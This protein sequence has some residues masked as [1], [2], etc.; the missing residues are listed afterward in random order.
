RDSRSICLVILIGTHATQ[1]WCADSIPPS[2]VRLRQYMAQVEKIAAE[3]GPFPITSDYSDPFATAV[4]KSEDLAEDGK[5]A[6]AAEVLSALINGQIAA[7]WKQMLQTRIHILKKWHASGRIELSEYRIF[8]LE[9]GPEW[10]HNRARPIAA[11]WQKEIGSEVERYFLIGALLAA[12]HDSEGQ[13]IVLSAIPDV[14]GVSKKAAADALLGVGHL[15]HGSGDLSGAETNW[16]KVMLRYA[17]LPAWP[18]AVFNLGILCKEKKRYTEA[19]A[20]FN[21]LL[22]SKPNDTEAYREYSHSSA[23]ELSQ[24]YEALS[25]YTIALKWAREAQTRYPCQ[26]SRGTGLQEEKQRN[27]QR[28]RELE[29]KLSE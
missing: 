18:E 25:N 15:L 6:E 21:T 23:V 20:F 14:D 28:I 26:S 24:C 16:S 5:Y 8:F 11:L 22:E 4:L 17:G 3:E 29:K 19:I 2:K 10:F 27:E 7:D 9:T 1:L 13:V 12:R